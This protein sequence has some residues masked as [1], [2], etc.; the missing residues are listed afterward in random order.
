[1]IR[2]VWQQSQFR[3]GL[4]LA[5]ILLLAALLRMGWP[6]LTEFKADEARLLAL[7]LDMAEGAYFPLRGID[8]SVGFPNSPV[9]VWLYALPLFIWK[10]VYAATLFTGFANVLAVFGCWWLVRRYW[11]PAAALLAALLFAANP[12]AVVHARKIWAQ[13]LLPPLVVGW[14]ITA[15]LIFI[16]RRSRFLIP[17]LLL[18][19]LAVLVHFAGIALAPVSLLLLLLYRKRVRSGPLLA[20]LGLALLAALPFLYALVRDEGNLLAALQSALPDTAQSTASAITF[21]L[22]PWRYLFLM[23][24][25][26]ELHS[27]AGPERFQDY[28]AQ[29]PTLVP[30]YLLLALLLVGGIVLLA[31]TL[32]RR[33]GDGRQR[34]MAL[35]L[36]L[37]LCA[38]PLLFT[39]VPIPVTLHYL[40]PVYPVPFI[41]IAL[42]LVNAIR[43]APRLL[44]P[45]GVLL[46]ATVVLQLWAW[47]A[48]LNFVTNEHTPGG[49]GT[50]LALKLEAVEA[51]ERLQQQT[52]AA[53]LIIA[54]RSEEPSQEEFAAVYDVLLRDIPH[55]FLNVTRSALFPAQGA[56]ALVN[57]QIGGPALETYFNMAATQEQI[58]LRSGE[59]VYHILALRPDSAP[60]PQ[61]Q[62]EEP[63]LFMNFVKWYG[64]DVLALQDDRAFV[65]R[66]HWHPADNPTPETYH[67]FNHLLDSNGQRLTQEDAPVFSA[68]QWQPGDSVVTS[69]TIRPPDDATPPWRMRTGL[70][71]FPELET[72]PLMDTGGNWLGESVEIPIGE[73]MQAAGR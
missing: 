34:E 49:F 6:G 26:A 61:E 8:S 66:I 67:F 22:T 45:A 30:A 65:W 5:L 18:L 3:E 56:V 53:E 63:H 28:L 60:V 46:A 73:D 29:I 41:A 57:A 15:A 4:F 20:G 71:R 7:A 25:G 19:A 36:L 21:S 9:S 17:H 23:S 58:P 59:G 52:Q 55:R 39:L 51:V 14:A 1:M 72:V 68:R 64:Y 50:P 62:F 37:W 2:T 11:G 43:R 54:G 70:Y 12:W 40:L 69:F 16:E 13:N 35:L 31:A 24:T 48:L 27:L 47:G 42:L 38:P 33:E 44:A 10:H 32:L